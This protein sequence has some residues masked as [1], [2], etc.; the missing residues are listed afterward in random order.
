MAVGTPKLLELELRPL[1]LKRDWVGSYVESKVALR[2]G[3]GE[4]PA[5]T[6]YVV[7]RNFGGLEMRSVG[8]PT[9]GMR[10]S[11]K[12]VPERSVTYLGHPKDEPAN[13]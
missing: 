3:W 11:I 6:V 13:G 1:R 7:S 8:C 4:L 2:N 5:G 12:K 9:C 10:L